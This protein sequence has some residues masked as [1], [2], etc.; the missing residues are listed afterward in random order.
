MKIQL[1]DLG[2]EVWYL[3]P[4]G[5]SKGEVKSASCHVAEDGKEYQSYVVQNGDQTLQMSPEMIH[6]S[7]EA[8]NAT[9]RSWSDNIPD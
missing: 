4:D 7:P 3:T 9:I 6:L 2:T 1:L 5:P 8:L